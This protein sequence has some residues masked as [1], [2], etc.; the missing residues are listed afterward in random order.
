MTTVEAI[1][2]STSNTKTSAYINLAKQLLEKANEI[3]DSSKF[4]QDK[5]LKEVAFYFRKAESADCE[6][7]AYVNAHAAEVWY[8]KLDGIISGKL[9]MKDLF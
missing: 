9:S 6:Y 7:T 5:M 2:T 8:S 4:L 1:R 3:A